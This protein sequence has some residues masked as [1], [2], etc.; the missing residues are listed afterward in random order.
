MWEFSILYCL[1]SESA[2]LISVCRYL[3]R[4]TYT[5]CTCMFFGWQCA[6]G[7]WYSYWMAHKYF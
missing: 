2:I 6:T 5:L 4:Y 7:G 1:I 3:P